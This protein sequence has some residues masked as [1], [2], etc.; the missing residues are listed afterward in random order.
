MQ[1]RRIAGLRTGSG[2]TGS[3]SRVQGYSLTLHSVNMFVFIEGGADF[4]WGLHS[5]HSCNQTTVTTK[6]CNRTK[7]LA[8]LVNFSQFHIEVHA[9]FKHN[10]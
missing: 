10:V 4:S 2:R 9:W 3:A 7:A 8:N 1:S 6:T 5:Y